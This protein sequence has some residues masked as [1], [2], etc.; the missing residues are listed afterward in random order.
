MPNLKASPTEAVPSAQ[1][2]SVTDGRERLPVLVTGG[3]EITND[4]SAVLLTVRLPMPCQTPETIT[5]NLRG[6]YNP[7]PS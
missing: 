3:V 1:D 5:A 2:V 7:S 4:D 6:T